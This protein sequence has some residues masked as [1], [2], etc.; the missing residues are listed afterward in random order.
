[1]KKR[2]IILVLV[3]GFGVMFWFLLREASAPTVQ[4]NQNFSE[5]SLA[6]DGLPVQKDDLIEVERP[7]PQATVSSPLLIK[8]KARGTWYFEGSFPIVV[9]TKDNVI[10]GKGV[11]TANGDS[12]TTEYVSFTASIN[13]TLPANTKTIPGFLILKKDN[14]SGEPRFD[15]QLAIPVTFI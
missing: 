8:G 4:S 10:I 6:P 11:A 1:M 15:N 9:M 14:P 5:Q 12:M 7:L 3:L 13:Y 2:Y